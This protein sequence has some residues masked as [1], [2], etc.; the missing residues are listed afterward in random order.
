MIMMM[1]VLA[2]LPNDTANTFHKKYTEKNQKEEEPVFSDGISIF[3]SIR[4]CV[5][6]VVAAVVGV[7]WQPLEL[8]VVRRP[9]L[10]P[11]CQAALVALVVV[12]QQRGG[13]GGAG[14]K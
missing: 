5:F 8:V 11:N 9:A 7:V 4:T 14:K 3:P 1:S 13:G 6:L 12:Q 2:R 10:S